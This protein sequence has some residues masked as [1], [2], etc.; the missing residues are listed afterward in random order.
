MEHRTHN[1]NCNL[2]QP[3]NNLK[4]GCNINLG[5]P[6]LDIFP[7]LLNPWPSKENYHERPK[8]GLSK[9]HPCSR[10]W[11]FVLVISR[12]VL[13]I[14]CYKFSTFSTENPLPCVEASM[15]DLGTNQGTHTMWIANI[16]KPMLP[17][18]IW[19]NTH[20]SNYKLRYQNNCS[21]GTTITFLTSKKFLENS[22]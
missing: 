21:M 12:I 11:R 19:V 14:N 17:F 1:P 15:C 13:E 22:Y 18:L 2:L 20:M 8:L 7:Y 16:Q 10:I 9:K 3:I 6:R 5:K 4:M